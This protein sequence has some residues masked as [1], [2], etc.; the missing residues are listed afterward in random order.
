[1]TELGILTPSL[2]LTQGTKPK[3]ND[4]LQKRRCHTGKFPKGFLHILIS[5][6][7]DKGFSI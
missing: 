2:E 6:T 5:R 7:V 3:A 4:T 1:M